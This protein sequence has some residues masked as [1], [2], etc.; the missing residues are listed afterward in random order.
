MWELG[1]RPSGRIHGPCC[2]D[3]G[4]DLDGSHTFRTT[5]EAQKATE[6]SEKVLVAYE[7]VGSPYM[8]SRKGTPI[9]LIPF[10]STCRTAFARVIRVTTRSAF[11]FWSTGLS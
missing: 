11:S 3:L 1:F 6:A 5:K 10:L 4:G 8:L 7:R 2:R 9:K